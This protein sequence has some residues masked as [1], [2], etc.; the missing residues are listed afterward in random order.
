MHIQNILYSIINYDAIS[1]IFAAKT[2]CS[3][4][5]PMNYI[6]GK[7]EIN[8]IFLHPS[9]LSNHP[10]F[11]VKGYSILLIKWKQFAILIDI[12]YYNSY[13]NF[14]EVKLHQGGINIFSSPS[15]SV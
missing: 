7:N 5:Q 13:Y 1:I 3:H 4:D 2:H 8:T 15:I 6:Q 14:A 10:V 12:L 9:S 11:L